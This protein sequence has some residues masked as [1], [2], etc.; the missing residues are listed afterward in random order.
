MSNTRLTGNWAG[1]IAGLKNLEGTLRQE[2]KKTVLMNAR[3]VEAALVLHFQNQDLG[4]KPLN[5]LY[6]KMKQKKGLSEQILIA[7]S[8]MMNS[9]TVDSRENG[10]QAFVGVNR[11]AKGKDGA[12]RAMIGAIHEYGSAKRGIPPRPFLRPTLAEK[13]DEIIQ[14]FI[15]TIEKTIQS[16]LT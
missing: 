11:Q 1:T 16:K 12:S 15:K 7:T 14:N 2:L 6:K 3:V 10:N 8:T 4:W 9:I 5:P 13:K